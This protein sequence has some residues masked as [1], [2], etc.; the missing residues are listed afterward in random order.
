M[1]SL[2]SFP[3][4]LTMCTGDLQGEKLRR[5]NPAFDNSVNFC[6]KT[7]FFACGPGLHFC[8]IGVS[9]LTLITCSMTLVGVYSLYSL[10]ANFSA[11]FVKNVSTASFAFSSNRFLSSASCTIFSKCSG[12]FNSSASK[13]KF[14]LS[15]SVF[16][17]LIASCCYCTFEIAM[18][19]NITNILLR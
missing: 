14:G 17:L 13:S 11:K 4:L 16:L 5:I 2:S 1:V 19:T 12:I 7:S 3:S 15:K 18:P 6:F 9:L 10:A 8:L